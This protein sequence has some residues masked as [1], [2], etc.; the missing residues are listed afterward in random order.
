MVV[1]L[2]VFALDLVAFL[3]DVMITALLVSISL[4]F[5]LNFAALFF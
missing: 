4:F 3:A 5:S 1:F 2:P